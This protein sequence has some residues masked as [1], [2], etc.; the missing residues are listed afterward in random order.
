MILPSNLRKCRTNRRARSGSKGRDT[1][2]FLTKRIAYQIVLYGPNADTA[3]GII[4]SGQAQ[5][6]PLRGRSWTS[7]RSIIRPAREAPPYAFR[8]PYS[9]QNYAQAADTGA[10]VLYTDVYHPRQAQERTGGNSSRNSFVWT[11]GDN[12][13]LGLGSSH[14]LPGWRVDTGER[15]FRGGPQFGLD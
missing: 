8:S 2:N 5:M 7:R 14:I 13:S 9:Y 12:Y 4:T 15:R 11:Q 6:L 1:S 3:A 10:D